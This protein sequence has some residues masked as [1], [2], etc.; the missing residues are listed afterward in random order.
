MSIRDNK[1]IKIINV[2]EDGLLVV[3]LSS[4]IMF[5]VYQIIARNLFSEGVVWIDPLLRTL[6]LWVGLSGAVVATRT[7]NHIRIDIFAKYFPP[8][9]LKI[10]QRIV[11]LFTLLICLII[12]W[13]AA[14]FIYSEYEYGT[15]AF[16]NVPSW[17]TGLIIPLSFSL[18]AA[19]YALLLISPYQREIVQDVDNNS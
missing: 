14:R 4:M 19:R 1:L 13:H 6:V 5:A 16:S 10:I 8:H 17:L 7:D 15:I 3:I 2:F 18:I 11:Y 9:I 12:A